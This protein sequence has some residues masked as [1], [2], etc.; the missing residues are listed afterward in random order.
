MDF[1]AYSFKLLRVEDACLS[2]EQTSRKIVSKKCTRESLKLRFWHYSS[3]TYFCCFLLTLENMSTWRVVYSDFLEMLK[4]RRLE[5]KTTRNAFLH[6]RWQFLLTTDFSK[7]LHIILILIL[8]ESVKYNQIKFEIHVF[9]TSIPWVKV[10]D[11]GW[12]PGT[13]PATQ[14]NPVYTNVP[15]GAWIK[16]GHRWHQ[17]APAVRFKCGRNLAHASIQ[18][19]SLDYAEDFTKIR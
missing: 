17:V 12:F 3:R 15:I 2:Q 9:I 8:M 14:V 7:Q 4:S 10:F 1:S 18:H 11:Y 19:S 16:L 6:C 13:I 5:I